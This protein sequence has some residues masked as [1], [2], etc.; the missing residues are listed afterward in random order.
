M[1]K[2]NTKISQPKQSNWVLTPE[3]M[4]LFIALVAALVIGITALRDT[5]VVQPVI[6]MQATTLTQEDIDN[7]QITSSTFDSQNISYAKNETVETNDKH[8]DIRSN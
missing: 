4:V 1:M 6:N 8:S 2:T 3:I 5:N 7:S